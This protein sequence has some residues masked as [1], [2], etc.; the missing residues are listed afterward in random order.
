[1][2]NLFYNCL[3]G[4]EI[5]FDSGVSK[6]G[7]ENVPPVVTRGVLVDIAGHKGVPMQGCVAI[8]REGAPMR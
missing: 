3:K 1:V 6:I 8:T 4:E 5:V 7:F 2:D